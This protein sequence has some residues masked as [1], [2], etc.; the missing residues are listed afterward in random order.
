MSSKKL[1]VADLIAQKD[2]LKNKKQRTQP[3][4]V[5]SLDSEIVIR[6]PDPAVAIEA[7]EMAQ[8]PEKSSLADAYVV[9]HTVVEPNLK[10]G[11]LQKA[12][13]CAEPT[14]IVKY[15]F[16]PGEIT[17]ISGHALQLAGYGSGV[18]KINQD[19]KN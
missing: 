2:Q 11:E 17:A 8:D 10:D 9:Y 14:D 15:I 12:Y 4:F 19:L 18:R 1:T 13:G 6:E 3:L 16:R 5:E 7:V